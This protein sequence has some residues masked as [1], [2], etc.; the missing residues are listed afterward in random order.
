[1]RGFG[2]SSALVGHHHYHDYSSDV[3]ADDKQERPHWMGES[4]E[5]SSANWSRDVTRSSSRLRGEAYYINVSA[6][7]V[8]W[9]VVGLFL[10]TIQC[11]RF[12]VSDF[13]GR[14]ST[15]Q[16][17]DSLCLKRKRLKLAESIPWGG[18]YNKLK[19]RRYTYDRYDK[20]TGR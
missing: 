12:L 4:F 11:S 14:H 3:A 9:N 1:M 15:W 2:N 5:F 18:R 7:K 6:S 17:D 13:I 8:K 16:T 10:A 20:G 19:I